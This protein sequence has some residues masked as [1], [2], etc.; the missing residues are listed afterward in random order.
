LRVGVGEALGGGATVEP[1]QNNGAGA[2]VA[3]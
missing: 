1:V 3:N 2:A